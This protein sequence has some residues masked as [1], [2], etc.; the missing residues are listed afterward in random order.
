MSFRTL[1]FGDRTIS[2]DAGLN[3]AESQGKL[4]RFIQMLDCI[5]TILI[6]LAEL[7]KPEHN[8]NPLRA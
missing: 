6:A 2:Y 5:Y 3:L 4:E 7:L 8:L 1:R